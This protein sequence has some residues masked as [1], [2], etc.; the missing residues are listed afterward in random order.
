MFMKGEGSLTIVVMNIDGWEE[1]KE[2]LDN[3]VCRYS[4]LVSFSV[5]SS[6]FCVENLTR[7]AA[8]NWLLCRTCADVEYMTDWLLVDPCTRVH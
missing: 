5:P 1:A 8:F 7:S 2:T 6:T 4:L 3:I